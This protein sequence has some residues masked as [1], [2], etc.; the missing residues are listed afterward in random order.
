MAPCYVDHII[1]TAP[2]L[3]VGAEFVNQT[4]G[5]MPQRGGEHPRM[6]THNLLLRLGEALFL[7]VISPNPAASRPERA[8]WFALDSLAA[9]AAPS[10]ATWVA[11]TTDLHTTAA[12]SS[13]TLGLIEPMTRGT[14]NWLITIPADGSLPLG[15]IAPTLIEWQAEPHPAAKLEDLGLSLAKLELFH[16]EPDRIASL[17]KSIEC[18]GPV[19]VFPTPKGVAPYLVAHINTP[20]G[21]RTLSALDN[22]VQRTSQPA[23]LT[24]CR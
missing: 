7:E 8:R 11:R 21:L 16:P 1:I 18:Q 4:L 14:L 6:G 19:S 9:D 24:A 10:L 12:V 20:N 23:S 15:G 13:E 5:V 22:P 3:E 2:D 17:L